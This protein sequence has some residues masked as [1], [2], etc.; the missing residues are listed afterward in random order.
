MVDDEVDVVV[1]VVYCG[2]TKDMIEVQRGAVIIGMVEESGEVVIGSQKEENIVEGRRDELNVEG[3]AAT[4]D[5][6]EYNGIVWEIGSAEE[7]LKDAGLSVDGKAT[8]SSEETEVVSD[9]EGRADIVDVDKIVVDTE[10]LHFIS[11]V[12]RKVKLTT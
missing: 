6:C 9:N 12:A 11:S 2:A 1:M 7:G 3:S 4:E 8:E 5:V 10:R